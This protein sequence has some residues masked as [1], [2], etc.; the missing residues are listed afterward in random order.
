VEKEG[1]EGSNIIGTLAKVFMDIQTYGVD[2]K[3]G[4]QQ[5]IGKNFNDYNVL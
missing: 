4:H 1:K 2:K 3:V 5:N